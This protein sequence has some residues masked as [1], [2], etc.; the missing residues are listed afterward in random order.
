[1]CIGSKGEDSLCDAVLGFLG[2]DS[3]HVNE[4]D[5]LEKYHLEYLAAVVDA[6]FPMALA[7]F[8]ATKIAMLNRNEIGL[9]WHIER[10]KVL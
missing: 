8:S 1:M 3:S 7:Y 5:R 2:V 4:F 10:Q 6:M 9:T